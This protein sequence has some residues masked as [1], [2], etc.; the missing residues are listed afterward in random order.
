MHRHYRL[1][2]N[3]PLIQTQT[4]PWPLP[5]LKDQTVESA[6]CSV[7]R[8]PPDFSA[9]RN[10]PQAT[11]NLLQPLTLNPFPICNQMKKTGAPTEM[12]P[13]S[14]SHSELD[15]MALISSLISSKK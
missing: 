4:V 7:Q 13:Y 3:P 15:R 2:T 1:W 11:E 12:D 9:P 5:L 6:V 8:E 10:V 14:I